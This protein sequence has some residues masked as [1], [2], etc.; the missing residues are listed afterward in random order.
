MLYK[1]V[2]PCDLSPSR[3]DE[4]VAQSV[5]QR[6]FNPMP[7]PMLNRAT[8]AIYPHCIFNANIFYTFFQNELLGQNCYAVYIRDMHKVVWQ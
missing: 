5:E 4:A 1:D 3:T 8:G 2:R 7:N 6:I